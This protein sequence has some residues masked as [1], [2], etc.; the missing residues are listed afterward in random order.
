[1]QV[2]HKREIYFR[3]VLKYIFFFLQEIKEENI[4]DTIFCGDT[5]LEVCIKMLSTKPLRMCKLTH[6]VTFKLTTDLVVCFENTQVS[7]DSIPLS[8]RNDCT[9]CAAKVYC[10]H[11]MIR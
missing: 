4:F 9:T 3:F 7:L 10:L 2:M 6:C 5:N 8:P 1:M 11:S